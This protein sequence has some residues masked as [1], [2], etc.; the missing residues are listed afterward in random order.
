MNTLL[1]SPTGDL[2]SGLVLVAHQCAPVS[3]AT[4]LVTDHGRIPQID[5]HTDGHP[6]SAGNTPTPLRIDGQQVVQDE[7]GAFWREHQ[8][9]PDEWCHGPFGLPEAIRVWDALQEIELGGDGLTE[10]AFL[11]FPMGT[12]LQ[13]IIQWIKTGCRPFDAHAARLGFYSPISL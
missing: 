1:R 13:H 9:V 4:F 11:G 3:K 7:T 5:T 6:Y 10:E 2:I 8:L 12:D